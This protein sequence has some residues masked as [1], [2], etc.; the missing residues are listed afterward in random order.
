[1]GRINWI[2][3]PWMLAAILLLFLLFGGF[4]YFW[5]ELQPPPPGQDVTLEI[6]QGSP[7]GTISRLLEEKGLI[8][9]AFVFRLWSYVRGDNGK[10]QAGTYVIKQGT[11]AAE[12]LDILTQGRTQ[13]VIRFTVPEGLTLEQTADL[14]AKK[15]IVNREKFIQAADHDTFQL[16]FLR[17][18]TPAPGVKHRLEGYLFPDTYEI[19][20]GTSEHQIIQMM[21]QQFE[22]K[23]TPAMRQAIAQRGLS[24][25]QVVTVASLVEREARVAEERPVIAAV[26]YN[27]L[28]KNPPMMLQI[29]ATVQYV[30]GHKEQLSLQDLKV[31]SPYNTYQHYGLPPGPIAS[32]GLASMQAAIYP[33]HNDYLF[34]VTKKDGSG[35]H[36]FARTYE[37]QLQN[38]QKSEKNASALR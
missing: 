31:D 28:Q 12:I 38:E 30:V 17:N 13:N 36:Y 18:M 11:S 25:S 5:G 32:P 21:L 19:Y 3:K 15:G 23:M 16:S 6:V 37:E 1:M 4:L 20:R 26:I 22:G 33:A 35:E 24:L 10:M 2:R 7:T 14:L 34:Y 8:R 9:N 27:R 29:D